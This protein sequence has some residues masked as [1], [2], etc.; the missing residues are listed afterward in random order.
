MVGGRGGGGGGVGRGDNKCSKPPVKK[1]IISFVAGEGW[2]GG[3]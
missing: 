3:I 2:S 1:V